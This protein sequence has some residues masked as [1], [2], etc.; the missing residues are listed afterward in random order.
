MIN[1]FSS[2]VSK[3]RKLG[4][5]F[6]NHPPKFLSRNGTQTICPRRYA[7]KSLAPSSPTFSTQNH[8]L[9]F[10]NYPGKL[11]TPSEAIFHI[12]K[13]IRA[14]RERACANFRGWSETKREKKAR[15]IFLFQFTFQVALTSEYNFY[16]AI[17]HWYFARDW[18]FCN[19]F[20]RISEIVQVWGLITH[21]NWV[22]KKR[23]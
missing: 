13:N 3:R 7:H 16:G 17:I 6:P 10:I 19:C 11:K 1:N 8:P 21:A 2:N 14:L 15:R 5:Q 20:Y 9:K 12:A 18:N 4:Q 22:L 23:G